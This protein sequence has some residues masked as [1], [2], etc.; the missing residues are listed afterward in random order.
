[1][2]GDHLRDPNTLT[3][4]EIEKIEKASHRSLYQAVVDLGFDAYD[5]FEQSTDDEKDVGEDITREMLDRIGGY[6]IQQR[7]FGNVDYRKARY[8]ILPEFMTRQALFVD[9]KAEKASRTATLQ[10][11]QTSMTIHQTRAGQVMAEPGKLPVV[12]EY[13]GVRFLTTTML[14]HYHYSKQTNVNV[15]H[16]VTLAAIPNGRL[17]DMY[18]PDAASS[19]WLAGRNAPTL[20]EDFR[21]RLSF[22]KLK[23]LAAWRVQQITYDPTNRRIDSEWNE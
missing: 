2:P 16:S 15:L 9:S 17:Q 14:V 6:Q 10:M 3:D 7:V 11:S 1:M 13:N 18:N 5:V 23:D 8:A 12:A 4:P 22:T 20:G 21:V 19:I